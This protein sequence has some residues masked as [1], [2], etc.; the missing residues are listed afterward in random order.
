MTPDPRRSPKEVAQSPGSPFL[1]TVRTA[2]G[3][4]DIYWRVRNN[5]ASVV[6][7]LLPRNPRAPRT[8]SPSAG[9]SGSSREIDDLAARI[10]R[11]LR[12]ESIDLPIDRMDF[13]RCSPFQKR[14]LL[15]ERRIPRGNV[16]TYGRIAR[17]LGLAGGARAVGRALSTN[18]FPVV[19]PCHRAVREDGRIGGFQGGPGMKRRLLEMEGVRFDARGRVVRE[20]IA[21]GIGPKPGDGGRTVGRRRRKTS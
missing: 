20:H 6:K 2:F 4:V 5:R 10:V 12:G 15:C 8:R 11:F 9:P 16:S 18:P 17:C 14:V 19:I 21:A 1:K 3:Q 7:I 13:G